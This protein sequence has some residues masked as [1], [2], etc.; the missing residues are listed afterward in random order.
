M[1]R[2]M[3]VD[4]E[5]N[6][7][8]GLRQ[9][10]R[11]QRK[12]WKMT[13]VEGGEEAIKVLA[14]EEF[15][16]IVSDMRMPRVDGAQL[17]THVK[18][19]YPRMVRIVLSGY[20]EQEAALRVV[21]I[22]H[23]FL[24]KPCDADT[25]RGVISR[26][27][28]LQALLSDERVQAIVG[29]MATLPTVPETYKL[30]TERLSD[31]NATLKEL[32]EIVEHDVGLATKVLQLVNSAFFGLPRQT[33]SISKAVSLLGV[34][35]LKHLVLGIETFSAFEGVD[36]PG[37]SLSQ[38]HEHGLLVGSLAKRILA[39]DA[40]QA[41]DAMLAGMLHDV[42]QLILA[43]HLPTRLGEALECAEQRQQPLFAAEHEL[44]GVSHAEVG[45][46]LLGLWGLPHPVVEA[47]A[48][49]HVP[50]RVPL[51][52]LTPLVAVHIADVLI[53][54]GPGTPRRVPRGELDLDLI[55]QLGLTGQIEHWRTLAVSSDESQAA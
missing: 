51:A 50:G 53:S 49:H 6:I 32:A 19:K 41:E 36:H 16:V 28:S 46:Y 15:D 24:S 25:L 3:F 27:C 5:P 55:D 17:L 9:L 42:G 1:K 48:S 8:A 37:F 18:E 33:S 26:A 31:P 45:A 22:A 35:M 20:S 29:D 13:F 12:N 4:D 40:R 23:Q 54:E 44:F 10:L 30:L 14:G 21:P 47:V 38:Q 39:D 34:N 2:I 7:L 52:G 43:M 11:K